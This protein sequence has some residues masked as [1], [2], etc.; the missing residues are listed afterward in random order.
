MIP[1]SYLA[2]AALVA[3]AGTAIYGIIIY[4]ALHFIQK[5]W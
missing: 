1:K 3:I 2:L 4:V 5:Y